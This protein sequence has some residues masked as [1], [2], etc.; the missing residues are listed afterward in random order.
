MKI[1]VALPGCFGE[2]CSRAVCDM[3]GEQLILGHAQLQRGAVYIPCDAAK[4]HENLN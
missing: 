3:V 2:W 4:F 1:C